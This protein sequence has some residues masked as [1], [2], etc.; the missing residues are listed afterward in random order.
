[1][2]IVEEYERAFRSIDAEIAKASKSAGL[3]FRSLV[4]L[5]NT[6]LRYPEL[7]PLLIDWLDNVEERSRLTD[8]R[9]LAEFR[10]TLARA[11]TTID[12][13]ETEAVALMF[14]QLSIRPRMQDTYLATF[15]NSLDYIAG[16]SDYDRMAEVAADRSLGYGRAPVIEWIARHG[17][18][19]ISVVVDQ[20]DDSSVRPYALRALRKF[21]KLPS[22]LR[23]SIERY[24]DD[25]DSEVRKQAKLTL[26]K[27]PD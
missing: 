6:R 13:R 16:S 17:V 8:P 7:I 25:P 9:D 21:K 23:P 14:D 1:M 12:A 19:G 18:S 11:L 10:E 22:D 20:L 5:A 15:S 24:L 26:K 3:P 27:L 2:V 4:E